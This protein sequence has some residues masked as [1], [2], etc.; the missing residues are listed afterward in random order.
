MNNYLYICIEI[1]GHDANIL[2]CNNQVIQYVYI[3]RDRTPITSINRDKILYTKSKLQM[4][5]EH[6]KR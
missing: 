4:G 2:I 6:K 1:T 5:Q 3:N